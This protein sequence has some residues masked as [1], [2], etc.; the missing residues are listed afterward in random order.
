LTRPK[1]GAIPVSG[2]VARTE[3][4]KQQRK[5][6]ETMKAKL[7]KALEAAGCPVRVLSTKRV[8]FSDLAR[9]DAIFAKC[10]GFDRTPETY[11]TAKTIIKANG[12]IIDPA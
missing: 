5:G 9:G 6:R 10:T 3:E 2:Y 4:A 1:R 11:D 7:N 12:A 8:S